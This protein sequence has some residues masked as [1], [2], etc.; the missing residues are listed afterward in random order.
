ILAAEW[1]HGRRSNWLSDY[2]LG[3]YDEDS[4]EYIM[5]GKTFKGLTDKELDTMTK[6]LQDI[7]Y[8]SKRGLV[9]VR[10]EIVVEVIVSEL[11]S[12]STYDA[13]IALRFARI[14]RIRQDLNP[15]EIL[16]LKQLE[17]LF[18]SQFDFKAR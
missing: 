12:S 16:T 2:H 6:E 8:E 18:N 1:G 9:R 14:K 10:P 17:D 15:K 11:Q 5:V 3:V 7:A 13:G 4:G